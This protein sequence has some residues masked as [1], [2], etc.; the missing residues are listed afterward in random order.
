MSIVWN[1]KNVEKIIRA[2]VGRK[3]HARTHLL[4]RLVKSGTEWKSK[5]ECISWCLKRQLLAA[6]EMALLVTDEMRELKIWPHIVGLF[7]DG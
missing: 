6:Q 1:L 3:E 7:V 4:R 5:M 2:A